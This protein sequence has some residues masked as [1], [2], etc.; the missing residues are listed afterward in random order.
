MVFNDKIK[1]TY[2]ATVLTGK[3][4]TVTYAELPENHSATL[5]LESWV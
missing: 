5:E 1:T 2:F 4:R 3:I